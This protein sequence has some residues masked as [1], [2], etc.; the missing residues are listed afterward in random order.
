M[1]D[2][3]KDEEAAFEEP[4]EDKTEGEE[5][6]NKEED[7]GSRRS[8]ISQKKHW[9]DKAQKAS[10]K[11]EELTAEL[12]RLK[13]AVKKPDDDKEAAAQEYI[14][15]QA[16]KV[17]EELQTEK[18]KEDATQLA[19]FESKVETIL[20]D[21]PDIAEEE[22]LDTIEEYEV[23]PNIALKIIQKQSKEKVKKPNM[24]KAKQASS[25]DSDKRPDDSKKTIWQIAQDEIKKI[26]S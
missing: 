1:E 7:K 16:R 17:F 19:D 3:I 13:S 23:E 22:L 21:N 14:R 4:Q 5:P 8:E 18:A 10:S 26:K 12:D 9:R 15:N 2:E 20:E 6:E 24:P 11:V 25:S